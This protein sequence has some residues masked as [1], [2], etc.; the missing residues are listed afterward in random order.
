MSERR[1]W[2]ALHRPAIRRSDPFVDLGQWLLPILSFVM[3]AAAFGLTKRRPLS[4]EA[5]EV[6]VV[7]CAA[8][9]SLLLMMVAV[10]VAWKRSAMPFSRRGALVLL[11]VSIVAPVV[12]WLR[13]DGVIAPLVAL[14]LLANGLCLV[15]GALVL[16]AGRGRGRSPT[17]LEVD[18]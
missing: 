4:L 11:I 16:V 15:A 12:L 3:V 2:R 9:I 5:S 14:A 1:S 13:H 10:R 8:L 7:A 18:P 17:T 6:I